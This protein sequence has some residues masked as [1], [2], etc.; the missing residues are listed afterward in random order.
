[1]PVPR[2]H[3]LASKS[4]Q[5]VDMVDFHDM[6]D[7]VECS[8]N[9]NPPSID[10]PMSFRRDDSGWVEFVSCSFQASVFPWQIG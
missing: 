1:V 9:A 7:A 4:D 10:L 6:R 2:E 8:D 5:D 3:E